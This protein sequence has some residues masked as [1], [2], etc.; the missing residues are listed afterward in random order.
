MPFFFVLFCF[1][2]KINTEVSTET[3]VP[4]EMQHQT[5]DPGFKMGE[6]PN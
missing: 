5:L 4:Q 2:E 1:L 6:Y 3:G